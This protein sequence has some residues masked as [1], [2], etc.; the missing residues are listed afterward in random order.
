MIDHIG[1]AVSDFETSKAFYRAALAP[2]GYSLVKEIPRAATGRTDV[3]G[4]GEAP[5]AD[6]WIAAGTPSKP[7]V[8]IAFHATGRAQVDAFYK[9][10]LAAGGRDNGAPGNRPHYHEHYYGA[11]VLDPDGH[12][13]EVVCHDPA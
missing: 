11:F 10:A 12:N 1:L 8:H 4:F 2:I 13:I 7:P 6:F 5:K 3:A 9:A